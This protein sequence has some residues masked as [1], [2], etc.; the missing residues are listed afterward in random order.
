MYHLT[1]K[2][3]LASRFGHIKEMELASQNGLFEASNKLKESITSV[4]GFRGPLQNHMI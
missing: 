3:L 2:C 1:T 4:V